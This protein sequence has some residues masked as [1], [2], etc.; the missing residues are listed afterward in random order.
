MKSKK[1]LNP[2]GYLSYSAIEMFRTSPDKYKNKYIFGDQYEVENDF[3]TIGKKLAS[4]LESESTTGDEIQD[5]VISSII[6]YKYPEHEI[7]E[8]FK[9]KHGEFTLLGVMDT[10][11]ETPRLKIR[12]YKTGRIKWTQKRANEHRQLKH[13]ASLV[14][15]KY[16]KLPEE[17]W[18]D[19]IPTEREGDGE[20]RFTGEPI[21]SFQVKIGLSDVLGY[22]A[23][24]TKVAVQ[25]DK[26]YRTELSI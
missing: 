23:E 13:Y 14:W 19:W 18:L 22:L 2:R 25:I 8:E 17:I 1:L 9:S 15:L 3:I 11:D 5:M 6:K 24:A 21:K 20:V 7:R 4:S 12:E 26:M 16:K 10:F